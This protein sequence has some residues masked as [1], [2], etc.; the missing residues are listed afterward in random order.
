VNVVLGHLLVDGAR[1]GTGER[2][3]H[4]GQIYGVNAQQLPSSVQ[5]IGLGHLHR[6]QEILA[7]AKTFYAGSLIELDFGETEQDKRVIVLEAR[8]GRAVSVEP[9]PITAGRRLREIRGSFHELRRIAD[10]VG[11]AFL[12]VT[13]EAREPLPGLAEQ[14]KE[15]LPQA[16][17]VTVEY[18]RE[19]AAAGGT[20]GGAGRVGGEPAEL[21]ARYY[22]QKNQTPPSEA[23]RRL[24]ESIHEEAQR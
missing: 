19:A 17:D 18:P 11:D 23:L 1:A 6:P 10:E 4:L 2:A 13:V 5:Y 22:E 21:F 16:L 8:P 9:V 7:P 14:V 20:S 15:L 24:F 12:R 3:L